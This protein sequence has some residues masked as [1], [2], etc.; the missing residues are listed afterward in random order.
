MRR[1]P[2]RFWSGGE[3]FVWLTGGALTI[4]L[5]LVGGLVG[6]ILYNG[7]GFFWPAD[8]VRLTLTDGTVMTG[9][10]VE[11]EPIPAEPG[12]YRIKLK[13]ANRDLYGADFQWVD[14]SRIAKRTYPPDVA[15][16]QRSEWGLLIGMLEEVRDGGRVIATGPEQSWAAVQARLP[17]AERVRREIRRI[18]KRDVGAING[19]QE[20]LRLALKKLA[21][22]GATGGPEV[23]ALRAQLAP[24][25]DS[26]QALAERLTELR[27][28]QPVSVVVVAD[29]GKV[30]DIPLAQVI[31]VRFPNRMSLLA[32]SL[33]YADHVWEFVSEDP[34][35]A[36][37]EGGVFPAI[38]GTVM[39]VMI[40]SIIVTPLGVL[41]AFYLREYARQGAF[42]SA[43]RIAVN[44]LAGVP[45]IVFGV[46]GVAFFI[47]F[48]GGTI[49]RLFYAEALPTPT[50]GTGGILWASLTL[51]LLT[52]PVVIVATEEDWRRSRAECARRLSRCRPPSSRP[53]CASSSPLSCRPS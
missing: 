16:I 51:A 11:R 42:V 31:E 32:K 39:M 22:R 4:S 12:R 26:Y 25:Q 20:R 6:L 14:E 37:T 33:A 28:S 36:N 8:V 21:L 3:P 10:V 47:Y 41:A 46:F 17:E 24:L 34:R 48:V 19:A 40:M 23:D 7:L 18:E 2:K 27:K 43:V 9:Q 29:G 53:C 15:V 49:D 1:S 35:E 30:K 45:S 52:V 38:F 44:N 5:I 13:V 50:Y